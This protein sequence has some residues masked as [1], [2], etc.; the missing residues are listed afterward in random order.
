MQNNIFYYF[1]YVLAILQ[2]IE[3]EFKIYGANKAT[4]VHAHKVHSYYDRISA[5]GDEPHRGAAQDELYWFER[6]RNGDGVQFR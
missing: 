6:A 3:T 4:C 1:A 5:R 2:K